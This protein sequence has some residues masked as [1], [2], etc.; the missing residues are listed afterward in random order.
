VSF[1]GD[2]EPAA[3][4]YAPLLGALDAHRSLLRQSIAAAAAGLPLPVP[5]PGVRLLPLPPPPTATDA[6]AVDAPGIAKST[7][8]VPAGGAMPDD[9]AWVRLYDIEAATRTALVAAASAGA[10]GA[11]TWAHLLHALDA[12][13]RLTTTLVDAALEELTRAI[14][15]REHWL[16]DRLH[17]AFLDALS[18]GRFSLRVTDGLIVQADEAF[19]AFL[20][21][22]PGRLIG[23]PAGRFIPAGKLVDIVEQSVKRGRPG[24]VQVR[25]LGVDHEP[26]TLD[27]IAFMQQAADRDE[28]HCMAVNVSQVDRDIAQRRLLSAAVEASNDLV[29]ITDPSFVIVY[30]NQAFQ[31]VTGYRPDEVIGRHP[32]FLQGRLTPGTALDRMRACMRAGR[33][34]RAELINYRKDGSTFWIDLSVVPVTGSEG[35]VE[36]WVSVGRDISERKQA[37]QEITRLAMEDHLTGLPNRRAAEARLQLEWDRARRMRSPFAL[38]LLDI[39]HFKRVNDQFGHEVGDRM[40]RHVAQTVKAALRGGDWVARWGGE[41][42]LIC[43]HGLDATG[44]L[45]AGER[46]REHVKASPL[47]ADAG[48]LAVTVSLGVSVY[49]PAVESTARMMVEADGLLYAAK[50]AGRDRVMCIGAADARYGG[51]PCERAQLQAALQ[52]SRVFAAFQPIV[53]LRSG[54]QVG[55][56]ALAR[57]IMPDGRAIPAAQ[58]MD[59]AES[60]HLCAR[61]DHEIVEQALK[62]QVFPVHAGPGKPARA[63]RAG[64]GGAPA[65]PPQ[66]MACFVNLSPQFLASPQRVCQLI[67]MASGAEMAGS[68]ERRLVIE[69]SERQGGDPVSLKSSLKPLVDAGFLLALDDFGS[70]CSSFQYLADL[71][72]RYLKIEGWMVARA[73]HDSRIRQLLETIVG[74]ARTF[75]LTTIAECVEHA[76]TARVLR[77]LGVDWAQ[78]FLYGAPAVDPG[79]ARSAAAAQHAPAAAAARAD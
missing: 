31:Q 53:E 64:A 60:L 38:A 1:H 43:F 57:I 56:E 20:G 72:I 14:S 13:D 35:E 2:G 50:E 52:E 49:R 7:A 63:P 33:A 48:D 62:A 11:A 68:S 16:T 44:A 66:R 76:D 70:G 42:F 40:L 23:V 79:R 22:E 54:A 69:I 59:T 45:A 19:A 10:D 73:V 78:G 12:S 51:V 21:T 36:H 29:L 67:E 39:D 46:M 9:A 32:R 58:F 75:Q 5:P 15:Q 34:V 71:P 65:V 6:A 27:I 8:Q 41:E 74:T 61:I 77:E 30:V 24:R 26:V 3:W 25:T 4:R 55:V 28:L 37:E 17:D 18:V 47:A